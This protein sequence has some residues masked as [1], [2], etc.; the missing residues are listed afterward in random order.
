MN[1]GESSFISLL[2]L[3]N[4]VADGSGTRS[5]LNDSLCML[6][7]LDFRHLQTLTDDTG[8]LQHAAYSV[9][10]REHGYCV[11]DN[12]R[13]L[14]VACEGSRLGHGEKLD[15]LVP[16]YLSF[17][18]HAL[19]NENGR[20]R[21]FMSYDRVWLEEKGSEDSH[22]RSLWSL[23]VAAASA[24]HESHRELAAMLFEQGVRGVG[25]FDALRATAFAILGIDRFLEYRGESPAMTALIEKLATRIHNAFIGNRGEGWHWCEDIVTY[26]NAALPLALIAAS[27][28]LGNEEML[29]DAIT[30]LRWLIESQTAPE[31]HLSI[32][33]NEGWMPR[34]GSRAKF[35]QQAVD[36]AGLVLACRA[37]H[38][39]TG[40]AEW[41][42]QSRLC[43]DWFLGA[44]DVGLPL[45]DPTTGGCRD[46]L[47]PTGVNANQGAES[48]VVWLLARMTMND[49]L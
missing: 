9:P 31:G 14:I 6:P 37:A 12:A 49:E 47:Q 41:L 3:Y 21:N 11:D 8:I 10:N 40:D 28:R 33:G 42:A 2:H 16:V 36:V 30:V 44:N 39:A 43:F 5:L 4:Q 25:E 19:N 27:G 1:A 23:G 26:S 45:Y 18:M 38:T 35:D 32:V 22:G 17:I 13:A 20:F 46:G 34:S 24:P 29:H 7:D 15:P 48:T